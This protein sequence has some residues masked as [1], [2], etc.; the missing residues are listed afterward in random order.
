MQDVASKNA[1]FF[2]TRSEDKSN[3][4]KRP[5]TFSFIN[6][7]TDKIYFKT[8]K[9]HKD[10]NLCGFLGALEGTRTPDLLVR[11][12]SLY[13]AELWAHLF[14]FVSREPH[15]NNYYSTF[16]RACQPL[17]SIFSDFFENSLDMTQFREFPGKKIRRTMPAI[18]F[19]AH[20]WGELLKDNP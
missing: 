9:I 18:S 11:S 3:L 6:L 2:R 14:V 10:R 5:N 13:P 19:S 4:L 12:Q 17:F 8:E 15:N 1:Y 7:L 16:R 20:D